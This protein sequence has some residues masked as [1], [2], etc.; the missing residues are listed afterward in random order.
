MDDAKVN[1]KEMRLIL[2]C[3]VRRSSGSNQAEMLGYIRGSA[4]TESVQT[5]ISEDFPRLAHQPQD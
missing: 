3:K 2:I 4:V 5:N 1:L